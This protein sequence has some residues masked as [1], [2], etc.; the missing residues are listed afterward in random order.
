MK[1][2]RSVAGARENS[3]TQ[4]HL[5]LPP[6][7]PRGTVT[8]VPLWFWIAFHVGVF[9]VLAIDLIGFHRREREHVITIKE[10]AT[11]SVVWVVLSLSFNLLVWHL[12]GPQAAVEFFTGYLIEYLAQRR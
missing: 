7:W 3:S 2:R 6:L 1:L 10:A 12:R 4:R 5:R 11:W 8:V 9:V